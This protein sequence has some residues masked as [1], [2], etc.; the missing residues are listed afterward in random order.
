MNDT[1]TDTV[2]RSPM[3]AGAFIRE[4]WYFAL[5]GGELARG[6]VVHRTLLGEP[7]L[8]GRDRDGRVFALRDTCPHRGTLLSR[9]AFDGREVECPYHGWRFAT[10]GRCTAIPSQAPD[11]RPQPADVRAP[12]YPV[13][14]VQGNVWVYMGRARDNLPPAP[15]VPGVADNPAPNLYLAM[16]FACDLDL[17]AAGLMDP[18][19]GAFVHRSALW[20]T[21][22][23]IHDKAKAF[24][25]VNEHGRI[26]WRMDRHA[27][28]SNSRAYR[29]FLGGAPATEIT[30]LMPSLRIEHAVT[31]KAMYAGL[32]A[33]TPVD[34]TRT[35]VHHAMY[36]RV[37]G[38]AALS[39]LLRPLVRAV[40]WRFLDQDRRAVEHMK[41]GLVFD[42]PT[43]LIRDADQQV[44][45]YQ[46]LKAEL[47]AAEAERRAAINP[48]ESIVLRW[49]S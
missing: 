7:V 34:A 13:S 4:A 5:A 16:A 3:R 33:C 14:E 12:A 2:D 36:W 28:S 22:A 49:R 46:R 41:A 35:M 18:A 42:P 38:G 11:Q 25:P 8:L 6:R 37:P 44:R 30:Y 15:R 24:S 48:I 32:T 26:G 29:I 43:M 23:S 31:S 10:D 45:W 19:H 1:R 39:A 40:A 17:A 27:A 21:K 47:L 9:G 20:R